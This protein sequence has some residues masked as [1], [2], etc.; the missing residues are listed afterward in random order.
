MK[1]TRN[2]DGR[3]AKGVSGNP[4][5]RPKGARDITPRKTPQNHRPTPENLGV[6]SVVGGPGRPPYGG[7]FAPEWALVVTIDRVKAKC[8]RGEVP[9]DTQ[10]RYLDL[11]HE[12]LARMEK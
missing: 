6:Y 8:E 1:S 7:E 5:G 12:A 11:F 4:S 2:N 3:W 10:E 9:I